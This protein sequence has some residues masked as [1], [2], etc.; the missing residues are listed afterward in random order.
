M[1]PGAPARLQRT[2]KPA[3]IYWT[4]CPGSTGTAFQQPICCY[5]QRASQNWRP[6]RCWPMG[7][8]PSLRGATPPPSEATGRRTKP[9]PNAWQTPAPRGSFATSAVRAQA[10]SACWHGPS[11][12]PLGPSLI[13][14]LAD[15]NGAPL[16][17]GMPAGSAA[18]ASHRPP[19]GRAQRFPCCLA[20]AA[21]APPACQAPWRPCCLAQATPEQ[22]ALPMACHEAVPS[23]AGVGVSPGCM[24]GWPPT[25]MVAWP[26]GRIT[27]GTGQRWQTQQR[28]PGSSR[29]PG[30]LPWLGMAGPSRGV[31]GTTLSNLRSAE[32]ATM[33]G[34][35][36]CSG[37]H[38]RRE[39]PSSRKCSQSMVRH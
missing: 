23:S 32:R 25:C 19:A 31:P 6:W 16:V 22:I 4:P 7:T 24:P 15:P 34:E 10:G 9:S 20:P 37:T 35:R 39:Q 11:T 8:R 3:A 36:S 18:R 33:P 5:R 13:L 29:S 12:Q 14:P 26:H 1:L 28:Q 27:T 2:P 21:P 38:G 30:R 17:L